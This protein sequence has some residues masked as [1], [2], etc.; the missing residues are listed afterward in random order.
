MGG[1]NPRGLGLALGE[2][3]RHYSSVVNARLR[4]TG[5][6]FQTRYGSVAM[7]E[8]HLAGAKEIKEI[9]DLVRCHRNSKG[10]FPTDLI[11]S[12]SLT[13]KRQKVWQASRIFS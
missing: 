13:R 11:L 5:H 6:L 10:R 4:V 12:G 9:G 7:D 3:H 2:A 8:T 1:S